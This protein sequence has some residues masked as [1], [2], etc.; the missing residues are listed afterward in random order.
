MSK[1]AKMAVQ[2]SP[3]FLK[4]LRTT[5]GKTSYV[6]RW[7][8]LIF[9]QKWVALEITASIDSVCS[10]WIYLINHGDGKFICYSYSVL[11]RPR[12]RKN[13]A[14]ISAK[15]R[16][17]HSCCESCRGRIFGNN[18]FSPSVWLLLAVINKNN[19]KIW[20]YATA[21]NFSISLSD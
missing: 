4:F 13:I 3:D 2:M 7:A 1:N 12:S 10:L 19:D 9:Q 18:K 11:P 21:S 6:Q 15:S 16:V 8:V 14:E 17:K 20:N 5:I